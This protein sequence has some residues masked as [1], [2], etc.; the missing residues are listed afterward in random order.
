MIGS[1]LQCFIKVSIVQFDGLVEW[2]AYISDKLYQLN[3]DDNDVRQRMIMKCIIKQSDNR[4]E[5]KV[6]RQ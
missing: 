2:L 3:H 4:R 1:N 5:A 6:I